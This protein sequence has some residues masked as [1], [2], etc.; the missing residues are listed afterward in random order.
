MFR[1]TS[2][3]SRR[4]P[5]LLLTCALA[6][7]A[8]TGCGKSDQNSAANPDTAPPPLAALP[9]ATGAASAEIGRAHV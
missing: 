9:L 4:L 6:A 7:L 3:K 2:Q 8:L 1:V 5:A